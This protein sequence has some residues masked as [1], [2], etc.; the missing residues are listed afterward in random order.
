[1]LKTIEFYP[2]ENSEF[3]GNELT[4]LLIYIIDN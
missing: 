3:T 4:R 2:H 1:M